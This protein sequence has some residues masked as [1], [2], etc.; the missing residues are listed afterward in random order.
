MRFCLLALLSVSLLVGCSNGG[1][2]ANA[3]LESTAP[4]M[5]GET[6]SDS[7]ISGTGTVQY[8]ELEGGFYGIVGDDG[9][10]KY[11]PESLPS[12]FQEDGLRVRFRLVKRDDVMSMRMW[13]TPVEVRE[14]ERL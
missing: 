7:V 4:G 14:I 11:D 3:P 12:A 9:D 5:N 8:V 13:G 6:A 10:V 2:T 1:E